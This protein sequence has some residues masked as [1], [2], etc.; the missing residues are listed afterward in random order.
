VIAPPGGHVVFWADGQPEQGLTHVNFKLDGDGER[1]ALYAGSDNHKGLINE[2]Y[3]GPQTLDRPWGRYPDGGAVWRA[4]A[5]TPGQPNR[6]PAPVISSLG[7]EP[8]F[9][10]PGLPVTVS[11]RIHDDSAIVSATLHYSA[12]LGFQVVPLQ[13]ISGDLYSAFIPSQ[14]AGIVVNYYVQARDDLGEVTT[15]PAAAPAV[16]YGYRVGYA[17][18]PLFINEF[19]AS[20]ATVNQDEMGAYEDWVELYNAGETPLDVGGMYL[21]DDLSRPTKWRFPDGAV[22]PPGG[23]LLIWT[24]DD[25]QDGPLHSGFKLSKTGEEIGLFERDSAA[26]VLIDRVIFGPQ[27]T[28]VSTGRWPDGGENWTAF[29]SPTPGW[30]NSSSLAVR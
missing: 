2:V 23:F 9:P 12:G 27:M 15:Y 6:Q 21:S 20:N 1:L 25:E 26:N 17:P 8:L 18:P 11:A 3:Y 14:T 29:E 13:P 5:P 28:D 24:D 4:L 22:I 10:A 16:S 19:L 30:N 7:H